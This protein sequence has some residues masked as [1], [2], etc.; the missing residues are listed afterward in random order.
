MGGTY[1]HAA[2]GDGDLDGGALHGRGGGELEHVH[3]GDTAFFGEVGGWVGKWMGG[4]VGGLM[5]R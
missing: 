4:W 2:A 3:S 1:L 5:G